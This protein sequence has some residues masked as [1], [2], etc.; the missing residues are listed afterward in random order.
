[1]IAC[2]VKACLSKLLCLGSGHRHDGVFPVG[3]R[4]DGRDDILVDLPGIELSGNAGTDLHASL[5]KLTQRDHGGVCTGLAAKRLA[6]QPAGLFQGEIFRTFA[7]INVIGLIQMLLHQFIHPGNAF[8]PVHIVLRAQPLLICLPDIGENGFPSRIGHRKCPAFQESLVCVVDQSILWNNGTVQ[9]AHHAGRRLVDKC[10]LPFLGIDQGEQ[11]Y[12]ILKLL[13]IS[14]LGKAAAEPEIE[15]RAVHVDILT[16][17]FADKRHHPQL[18]AGLREL[19]DIDRLHGC[20]EYSLTVSEIG[21][22]QFRVINV[23]RIGVEH[24]DIHILLHIVHGVFPS[25]LCRGVP[26]KEVLL[27]LDTLKGCEP[28]RLG[29]IEYGGKRA[30]RKLRAYYAGNQPFLPDLLAQCL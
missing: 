4:T 24:A 11:L 23:L 14:R 29:K 22:E 2:R 21:E 25:S 27:P 20:A 9:R 3:S 26:R 15:G 13:L 17:V 5:V 7:E 1:M 19:G 10:R 18:I 28:V 12:R 16:A 30:S 8:C 6:D